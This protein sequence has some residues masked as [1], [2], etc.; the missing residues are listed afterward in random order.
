MPVNKHSKNNR[1]RMKT[2][3]IVFYSGLGLLVPAWVAVCFWEHLAI[4]LL[5]L[6]M[7]AILLSSVAVL[8]VRCPV[9]G[10]NLCRGMRLPGLLPE[11]CPRCGSEVK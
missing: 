10:A 9:C 1:R 11:F 7:G 8:W 5:G 4:A 6:A 2:I 3:R